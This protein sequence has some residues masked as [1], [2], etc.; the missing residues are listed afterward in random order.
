[1]ALNDLL[2]LRKYVKDGASRQLLERL[3]HIA[4]EEIAQHFHA[5]TR[6]WAGPHSRCYSTLLDAGVLAMIQRATESRV[7]LVD[8]VVPPTINY[9]LRW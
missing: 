3:Y 8:G 9:P 4:W 2:R 5:P 7:C 1:M 6:Q